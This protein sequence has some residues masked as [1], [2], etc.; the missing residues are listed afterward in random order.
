MNPVS[1]VEVV[2][3]LRLTR[4]NLRKYPRQTKPE[5]QRAHR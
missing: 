4:P 2:R 1:M 3:P 5:T